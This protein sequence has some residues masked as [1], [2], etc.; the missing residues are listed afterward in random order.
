ML[1]LFVRALTL[2]FA[3][4]IAVAPAVAQ[5]PAV[6]PQ[7]AEVDAQIRPDATGRPAIHLPCCQCVDGR[8]MR[9]RLNTRG[10]PWFV[11][12]PGSAAFLPVAAAGNAAWTTALGPAGWVGPQGAGQAPGAYIY[13][14]RVVMPRC[15]IRPAVRVAGRFAADNSATTTIGST[16]SSTPGFTTP[17]IR[18]FG[19]TLAIAPGGTATI[20]ITVRN[21]EGPTG[22]IALGYVEIVCPRQR[23]DGRLDLE[24]APDRSEI[25]AQEL[26]R[27]E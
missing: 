24:A 22:L 21:N 14:L 25:E 7:P 6:A 15:L 18:P 4:G 1:K 11:R 8:R 26:N 17:A 23:A 27:D 13:E 10:A 5:Q 19:G 16:T 3:A 9:V 2:M 12:S 20:R